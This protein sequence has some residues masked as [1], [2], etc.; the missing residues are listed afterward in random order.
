MPGQGDSEVTMAL[1]QNSPQDMSLQ[2]SAAFG[3]DLFSGH[4]AHFDLCFVGFDRVDQADVSG[5]A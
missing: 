4:Q 2:G 3:K 1:T 5:Y